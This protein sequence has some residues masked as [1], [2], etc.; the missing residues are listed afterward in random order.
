[1]TEVKSDKLEGDKAEAALRIKAGFEGGK[2]RQQKMLRDGASYS[3]KHDSSSDKQSDRSETSIAAEK[4][5]AAFAGYVNRAK[6]DKS[7]KVGCE[8]TNV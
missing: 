8:Y 5:T 6:T 2:K 7:K 3:S 1:M 4:L